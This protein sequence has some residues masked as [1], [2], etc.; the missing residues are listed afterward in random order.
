MKK[1]ELPPSTSTSTIFITSDSTILG[2]ENDRTS[3]SPEKNDENKEDDITKY[4]NNLENGGEI[5]NLL[6]DGVVKNTN[7]MRF[8]VKTGET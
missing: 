5:K 6:G 4:W 7:R 2:H 8:E 1:L 3:I